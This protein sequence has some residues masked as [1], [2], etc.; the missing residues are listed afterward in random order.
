MDI[1]ILEIVKAVE[2]KLLG[3]PNEAL[4]V[5]KISTD[6]RTLE[7]EDVFFALRGTNF[8]GHDFIREAFEKGARHFVLSSTEKVPA[9]V[10]KAANVVLVADT[11]KAYGDLAKFYR[12][13]FRIP[14]IAVTGS[15]G[16]TTVKEMLAHVLSQKFRVLKNRGTEN[17]LVGVP[18][19]IF[20]LDPSH[21]VIVI[22]MGTN[23]PGEIDRLSS[24]ISP[25][26]GIVTH[27]GHSH[28]EGLKDLDGVK[29][30]KL[31]ILNHIDRGGVLLLNGQDPMLRDVASG[32]HKVLR[33]GFL[34]EGNDLMAGQIWC[35]EAGT[36]FHVERFI[37]EP[38]IERTLVETPLIGRHNVLNCLLAILAAGS[39]G[40]KF[41]EIREGLASFKAVNGRLN[42]KKIADIQFIDDSYNSNPSSFRAALDTLKEFKIREKKGVVC[43]DMLE[44]GE[45]SEELH[46]QI[47][48]AMA[49]FL[50]DFVIAA[51]PM[52]AHLVDE[53]LKKGFD[54]TRIHHVKDSQEAGKLCRQIASAGDFVLVK[55]SRG[56]HMEKVFECF[57]TSSTR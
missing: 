9:E 29:A 49:D 7:K 56:M 52:N 17:N 39:L 23:Q 53:A 6:T 4:S 40:M 24:I 54:P 15:S 57:T 42:F 13:K 21:E 48:A 31:R 16:K 22:E 11:L 5:H 14:A 36:T 50:F 35:H 19:T 43:G 46:R 38:E 41:S 45:K 3:E 1:K 26:I 44:L 8:D 47:G 33:V 10:K 12:Q 20:Q 28:L 30:E 27:I 37:Y 32:M 25:Q 2:G 34:K 51:G 55:G 18:K